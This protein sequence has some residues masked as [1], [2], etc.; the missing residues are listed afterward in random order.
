MPGR[1][2]VCTS[3]VAVQGLVTERVP[4]IFL[5]FDGER[6]GKMNRRRKLERNIQQP[7]TSLGVDSIMCQTMKVPLPEATEGDALRTAFIECN[8]FRR[9]TGILRWLR[10]VSAYNADMGGYLLPLRF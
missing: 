4:R 2:I 7:A 6:Q 3:P 5:Y 10:W 9:L 1:R 8:S